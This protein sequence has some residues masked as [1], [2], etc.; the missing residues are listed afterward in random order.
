MLRPAYTAIPDYAGKG[1]G[2][3]AT[4]KDISDILSTAKKTALT[5]AG[6]GFAVLV[7]IQF[8]VYL[9]FVKLI[10]RPIRKFTLLLKSAS[11]GD[12]SQDVDMTSILALNNSSKG[13][14]DL[15]EKMYAGSNDS[16]RRLILW[17]LLQKR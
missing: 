9:L 17:P 10:D 16:A 1:V 4:P 12:L 6:I 14:T 13:L 5:S 15:S 11:R 3:L 7:V 2:I 8:F